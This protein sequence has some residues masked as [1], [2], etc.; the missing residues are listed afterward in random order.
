MTNRPDPRQ[1]PHVHEG[2]RTDQ[3]PDDHYVMTCETCGVKYVD[4]MQEM[5]ADSVQAMMELLYGSDDE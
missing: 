4:G 2:P 1:T 5:A 3:T